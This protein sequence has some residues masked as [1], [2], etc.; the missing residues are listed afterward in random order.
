MTIQAAL[1]RNPNKMSE[2]RA[3]TIRRI[4][5]IHGDV[6]R[7]PSSRTAATVCGQTY[8]LVHNATGYVPPSDGPFLLSLIEQ[9]APRHILEL[10][11]ASGT[12][13]LMMLKF[14]DA[15]GSPATLTSVDVLEHYFGDRSRPVGFLVFDNINPR[16]SLWRLLAPFTATDF[17][18]A[19]A[20]RGEEQARRYDF[21]L[22]DAHH[23]HP[24][25]ALDAL[26][27]LPFTAPGTWVA[28]HDISLSMIDETE[29]HGP[30]FL[31]QQWSGD[32]CM[33]D[34]P[35]PNIGAIRLSD[36][37]KN[38]VAQLL[39]ILERPWDCRPDIYFQNKI[40]RHLRLILDT[41]QLARV[42]SA[43]ERHAH[44]GLV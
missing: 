29:T 35:I 28:L 42:A 30:Q 33:S 6:R 26:C 4:Q 20:L 19:P 11:V 16:P 34:D 8:P 15:I 25:A 1:A 44:L 36:A 43:F 41:D 24:W 10:G 37:G 22:I 12:A 32:T 2:D 5:E 7:L 18:G 23:G 3:R 9:A 14:L 38:D 40:M 27:L 17:A 21:L 39:D 31:L 13:S